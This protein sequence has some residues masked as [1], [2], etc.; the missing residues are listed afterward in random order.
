MG[1]VARGVLQIWSLKSARRSAMSVANSHILYGTTWTFGQIPGCFLFG[2]NYCRAMARRYMILSVAREEKDFWPGLLA[3]WMAHGTDD[4]SSQ[5]ECT[6][7][8][9]TDFLAI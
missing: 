1:L 3:D 4:S 7:S 9:K 8:T 6:R 5:G 2:M